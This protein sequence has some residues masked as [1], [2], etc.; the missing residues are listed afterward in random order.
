[1]EHFPRP[2][3]EVRDSNL[4]PET[5]DPVSSLYEFPNFRQENYKKSTSG[6]DTTAFFHILS[7]SVFTVV[8][9]FGAT[10]T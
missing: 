3:Q 8:L 5:R 10:G 4:C 6:D 2:I 1:M 7:N 9:A